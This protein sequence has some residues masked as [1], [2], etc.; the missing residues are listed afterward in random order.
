MKKKILILSAVVVMMVAL[1]VGLF[2]HSKSDFRL[3]LDHDDNPQVHAYNY[4]YQEIGVDS[5]VIK[6]TFY[7][8]NGNVIETERI[9]GEGFTE[10]YTLRAT[11]SV[12][13][14]PANCAYYIGT[15]RVTLM[16]GTMYNNI[17]SN[18]RYVN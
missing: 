17:V 8:A 16:D 11:H 9:G 10:Y 1:S 14:I 13:T 3:W 6:L 15:L 18:T 7:D 2:A 4:A 12:G 5:Y